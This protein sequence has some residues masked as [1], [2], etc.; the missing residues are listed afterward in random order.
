MAAGQVADHP[1]GGGIDA[2]REEALELPA[3]FVEDAQ[4]GIARAGELAGDLEHAIQHDFEVEL[5]NQRAADFEKAA[6]TL[7]VEMLV[8]HGGD[9]GDDSPLLVLPR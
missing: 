1:V 2:A 6:K 3:A 8:R 4:R 5:A 7:R 9:P